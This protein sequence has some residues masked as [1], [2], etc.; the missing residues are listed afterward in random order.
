V[1]TRG[2]ETPGTTGG[3]GGTGG[4]ALQG[5]DEAEGAEP[6]A[7]AVEV[8]GDVAHPA[9]VYDYVRGGKDNFDA[10]RKTAEHAA[11]A[12]SGGLDH[13]RAAVD[14]NQQFLA[15]AVR[16]LVS[17]AGVRQF[18]DIGTGI[19]GDDNTHEIA[20]ELAPESRVVYVDD[21]AVVLANAHVLRKSTPEGATAYVDG[22]PREPDKILARVPETLDLT[23]P[24]AILLVGILYHVTDDEDPYGIVRRLLDA[25]P[26]GSHLVI[27]HLTADILTDEVREAAKRI[28]EQPG[29]NLVLRSHDEVLR[30]FAGLEVVEPGVVPVD[31]WRP[32]PDTPP[33]SE[34]FPTPFYGAMGR[35]A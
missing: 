20:Q 34:E 7:R 12:G 21:D 6:G 18:L 1:V 5:E 26:A 30:F 27:S 17:E 2:P 23:K 32:D 13:A 10:D 35:K 31:R 8:A 33:P 4:S 3:A 19:P 25:V 24:V 22:N 29:F 9:R 15:R 28:N 14:T 16:Y 11:A